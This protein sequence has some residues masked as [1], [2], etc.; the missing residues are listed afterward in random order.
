VFSD[1]SSEEN[2]KDDDDNKEPHQLPL[3]GSSANTSGTDIPANKIDPPAGQGK[4]NLEIGPSK[5]Q[6]PGG[7]SKVPNPPNILAGNTPV[8]GNAFHTSLGNPS[9]VVP[10]LTMPLTDRPPLLVPPNKPSEMERFS[11]TEIGVIVLPDESVA[12][13]AEETA[14][15]RDEVDPQ[16]IPSALA[17]ISYFPVQTQDNKKKQELRA[18]YSEQSAEHIVETNPIEQLQN[19]I[20][21]VLTANFFEAIYAEE[22][23]QEAAILPIAFTI[24]A[25]GDPSVLEEQIEMATGSIRAEVLSGSTDSSLENTE[26]EESTDYRP[27]L[28][29]LMAGFLFSLPHTRKLLNQRNKEEK[30]L[31]EQV[32]STLEDSSNS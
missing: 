3:P 23:A 16:S 2:S 4:T 14:A 11:S 1:D 5:E 24:P 19:S 8:S 13:A 6:V 9:L 30:A 12:E 15:S 29:F 18:T 26:N 17:A 10:N 22:G 21:A 27:Y 20:D 25:V 28:S 31:Q 32:N 7:D